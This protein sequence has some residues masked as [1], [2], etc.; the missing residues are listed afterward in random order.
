MITIIIPT[1]NEE[2]Y[3]EQCLDGVGKFILPEDQDIEILVIDG[4]SKDMTEE[5]V[6]KCQLRDSKIQIL[7]NPNRIQSSALNIGISKAKGN[8]ILRL[9]AHAFYPKTI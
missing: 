8:W 7:K 2:K 6:K 5:I 9:D 3:I 1:Y 4:N